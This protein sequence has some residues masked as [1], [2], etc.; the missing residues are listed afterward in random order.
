MRTDDLPRLRANLSSREFAATRPQQYRWLLEEGPLC[1]GRIAV[2][3]LYLVS[4]HADCLQVL[5]DPRWLRNRSRARG[6][7]GRLP[8][9]LPKN[10]AFL[11][12]SMIVED[13]PEHLRLRRL[14]HKA[15][16]P[17]A[18]RQLEGRVAEITESILKGLED[19]T[20][21]DLTAEFSL[22][23]P[24][25]MIQEMMGLEPEEM[26]RFRNSLRALTTGITGWSMLRT[27]F[28]DLPAAAR[29]VREVIARKRN[30]P[31]EDILT[32]LIHAEE[33]GDQLS[34][35][36]LVSLTF[37]LIIAG[38][39]TTVHLL[40]NSALALIEH[41]EAMERL[42]DDA[43]ITASGVEELLR[44]CGPIHGTKPMFA[45]EE[46]EIRGHRIPRGSMLIPV[47]GAA[48]FDADV[49]ADPWRLDLEREPNRHLGFGHGAH[50]CLGASLARM[51]ARVVL[52]RLLRAFPNLRLAVPREEL[53]PARMP[54]W[55]RYESMPVRLR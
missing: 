18:T 55:H 41:P 7:G 39:E 31:G 37:L 43:T 9:P 32:A 36:E 51:E 15:F 42:R 24:V 25:T 30:K 13:D 29:W 23:I 52:P 22:P 34:E 40:S 20:E 14:V 38:Y 54:L 49:F 10:I 17:N 26:P 28:K 44:Y 33:D 21:I 5:T 53:V 3:G 6:G 47:L 1:R 35:D 48:N 11:A 2:L 50:F 45:A 8:F 46:V 4:R 16:T 19:K 12:Q 27:M